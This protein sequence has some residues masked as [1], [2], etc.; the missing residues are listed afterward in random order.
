MPKYANS[1][2]MSARINN[3]VK[4]N[5]GKNVRI[6]QKIKVLPKKIL[7]RIIVIMDSYSSKN[8]VDFIKLIINSNSVIDGID[9]YNGPC[10]GTK[11]ENTQ[12][13]NLSE[14]F[15]YYYDKGYRMFI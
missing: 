2:R 5:E 4:R 3:Y 12:I 11:I 8:S 6:N 10:K 1:G 15:Q 13:N 9:M 7:K 14:L